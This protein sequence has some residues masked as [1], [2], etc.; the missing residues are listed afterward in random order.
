MKLLVIALLIAG[1]FIFSRRIQAQEALPPSTAHSIYDFKVK[2]ID[3]ADKSL[4][5]Y[6]GKVLLVVNTASRCGFTPQYTGLQQL[7]ENCGAPQRAGT[8]PR[9]P[10]PLV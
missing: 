2:T 1:I 5:D 8:P 10:A 3:G 9:R 4:A 6:K 7:Y